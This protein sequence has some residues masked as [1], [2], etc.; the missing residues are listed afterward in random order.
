LSKGNAGETEQAWIEGYRFTELKDFLADGKIADF[1]LAK[2]EFA[3]INEAGTGG[4]RYVYPLDNALSDEALREKHSSL[5]GW[6][7]QAKL[8][9]HRAPQTSY[10]EEELREYA[11][12]QQAS[13][14]TKLKENVYY[15]EIRDRQLVTPYFELWVPETCVDKVSYLLTLREN[16]DGTKAVSGLQY[17]Y[18]PATKV[19]KTITAKRGYMDDYFE[20][21]SWFGGHSF[22]TLEDYREEVGEELLLDWAKRAGSTNLRDIE[23]LYQAEY[24]PFYRG[25][26][27][28]NEEGTGAY[29]RNEPSDVQW[30]KAFEAEYLHLAG[31]LKEGAYVTFFEAPEAA[32]SE[33]LMKKLK[34]SAGE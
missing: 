9:I 20:D 19:K 23:P 4:Y 2:Q 28:V 3:L 11:E 27:W 13:L 5:C 10:T 6:M 15:G 14:G 12:W 22:G 34:E 32:V 21:Y 26:Y 8:R 17:Y 7:N 25:L 33:D 18:A 30:R 29:F 24:A 31:L 1:E 16:S